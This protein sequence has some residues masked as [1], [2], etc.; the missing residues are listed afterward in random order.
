[1]F[2]VAWP[3]FSLVASPVP[4]CGLRFTV[5][6]AGGGALVVVAVFG[7][8]ALGKTKIYQPVGFGLVAAV[9]LDVALVGSVPGRC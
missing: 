6:L 9:S 8:F 3:C 7:A 2:G 5:G 4:A 1:V